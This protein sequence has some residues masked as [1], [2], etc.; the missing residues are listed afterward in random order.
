MPSWVPI[1]FFRVKDNCIGSK[2]AVFTLSVA[3]V[4]QVLPCRMLGFGAYAWG[5]DRLSAAI[6]QA[7]RKCSSIVFCLLFFAILVQPEHE[8][9]ILSSTTMKN[10][11][12]ALAWIYTWPGSNWRPSACEADVIATRPQVPVLE[13]GRCPP[14]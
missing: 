11:M 1:F 2:H 5:I 7:S 12:F 10:G 13:K 4:L 8:G 6:L 14:D 9:A 3:F